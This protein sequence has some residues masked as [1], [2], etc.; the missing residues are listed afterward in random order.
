M[1]LGFIL[2]ET[3]MSGVLESAF[4]WISLFKVIWSFVMK[5]IFS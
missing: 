2:V 3:G 5:H 1:V 4:F